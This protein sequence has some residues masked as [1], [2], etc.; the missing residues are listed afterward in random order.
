MGLTVEELKSLTRAAQV[1]LQH[2]NRSTAQLFDHSTLQPP[3]PVYVVCVSAFN[4][5][6]GCP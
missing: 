5:L 6:N 1:A 3:Y 4:M 2:L